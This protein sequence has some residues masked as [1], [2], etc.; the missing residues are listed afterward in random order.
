[1]LKVVA[2]VAALSFLWFSGPAKPVAA[3]DD[4]GFQRLS[5]KHVEIVTDLPVDDAIREL[6]AVF[7]AAMPEWCRIFHVDPAE[8]AQ[9]RTTACIMGARE[10][11][12][13]AGLLPANLPP[14]PHGYQFGDDLWVVEQPSA[15]YRRHL[16]LHEGTHWFMVRKFGSAGPPWLME[17]L[18]EWL[19]THRWQDGQLQMG[20]IPHSPDDVPMWGRIT[21]IQQQLADGLAPSLETI[22]HYDARAHQSTDAYAWSWAAVVFFEHHPST[23]DAFHKLLDG[24]LPS[25]AT[26][27]T[28]LMRALQNRKPF[29]R[30]EWS[31]MLTGLDYGFQPERELVQLNHRTRPLDQ[32][33]TVSVRAD[34]GWQATGI[35]VRAGQSVHVSAQGRYVVGSEPKPWICEP[36]GVTLRYRNGQPLGKLLLAIATPQP[37]E[38]EFSETLPIAPV[39]ADARIAAQASGE[40]LLRINETGAGLDDNSGQLS[41]TIEPAN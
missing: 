13:A 39:G 17:G 11:F 41:V 24:P 37:K 38:P 6:P 1:M 7:D 29:V 30:A 20:I 12:T 31:A 28:Q 8:V 21:L 3:A 27:T 33:A 4:D 22:M 40:I 10:R 34:N 2:A 5:G 15:Y 23:R 16:L 18:A 35:S 26:T 9:W 36:Q 32:A 14:F 25:D 19:A